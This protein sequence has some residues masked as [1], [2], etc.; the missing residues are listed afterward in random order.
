MFDVEENLREPI[1]K[2][3]NE[4]PFIN[5]SVGLQ[6]VLLSTTP[7]Q[8]VEYVAVSNIPGLYNTHQDLI[9]A[10]LLRALQWRK[11]F[12]GI[13]NQNRNVI[14]VQ[15]NSSLDLGE[16]YILQNG[17]KSLKSLYGENEK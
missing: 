12:K 17:L 5:A 10:T 14:Q 16:D 8:F 9:A 3:N 13:L 1:Y 7:M 2:L 6:D 15:F 11:C 4:K